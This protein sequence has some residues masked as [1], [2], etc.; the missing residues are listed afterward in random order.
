MSQDFLDFLAPEKVEK[1][2]ENDLRLD[3]AERLFYLLNA[4]PNFYFRFPGPADLRTVTDKF[5]EEECF[6]RMADKVKTLLGNANGMLKVQTVV[7]AAFN[8]HEFL[9]EKMVSRQYFLELLS[10]PQG[11][12]PKSETEALREY[13]RTIR[14]NPLIKRKKYL[15][16]GLG[17]TYMI[18]F[19]ADKLANQ[20]IEDV[21][22]TSG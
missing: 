15:L 4:Q 3:E 11:L 12:D 6:I 13:E 22:K 7:N 20:V 14:A 19:D 1:D 9:K 8:N 17:I 21:R 18:H 10:F 16:D 2:A 5:K